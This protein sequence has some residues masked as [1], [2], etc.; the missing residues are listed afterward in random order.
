MDALRRLRLRADRS[1]RAG[2]ATPVV[3]TAEE[4]IA[5]SRGVASELSA[6]PDGDRL[7]FLAHLD[8]IARTLDGRLETLASALSEGREQAAA[9]RDRVAAFDR[10]A[11]ADRLM[12]RGRRPGPA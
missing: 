5:L 7:L 12:R 2:F 6:L 3:S 10:Y 11:A 8:D 9:A 4:A 1:R